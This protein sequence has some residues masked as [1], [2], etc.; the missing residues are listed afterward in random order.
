MNHGTVRMRTGILPSACALI[1]GLLVVAS[2]AAAQI[3]PTSD[4]CVVASDVVMASLALSLRGLPGMRVEVSDRFRSGRDTLLARELRTEIVGNLRRA[5]IRVLP[6]VG[7]ANVPGHPTLRFEAGG[8]VSLILDEEACLTRRP[9]IRTTVVN[10]RID[11]SYEGGFIDQP[12]QIPPMA[13]ADSIRA[14]TQNRKNTCHE[15]EIEVIHDLAMEM[16]GMFIQ[17]YR[18]ENP[19]R[20]GKKK[21]PN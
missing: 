21:P 4:R 12:I 20:P 6:N 19:L 1:T 17:A 14:T 3:A 18:Q 7:T 10:Y 13:D 9:E 11:S 5:G 8:A 16:T 15:Q 2:I